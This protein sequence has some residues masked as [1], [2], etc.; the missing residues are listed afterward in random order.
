MALAYLVK[1]PLVLHALTTDMNIPARMLYFPKDRIALVPAAEASTLGAAFALQMPIVLSGE[2]AE[3]AYNLLDPSGTN[4]I[5]R[6]VSDGIL[7]WA[8]FN[9]TGEPGTRLKCEIFSYLFPNCSIPSYAQAQMIKYNNGLD[10]VANALYIQSA[11]ALLEFGILPPKPGRPDAP[12][13]GYYGLAALEEYARISDKITS[14]KE[15]RIPLSTL[16]FLI[17]SMKTDDPLR[18]QESAQLAAQLL[19]NPRQR[20]RKRG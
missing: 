10:S 8:V 7:T 16:E 15:T 12:I 20:K 17:E 19:L 13:S 3:T 14:I 9:R 6:E 4:G 11:Q 1:H 5:A 2:I 18:L